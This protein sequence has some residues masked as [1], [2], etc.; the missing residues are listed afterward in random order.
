MSKFLKFI[1]DI[2]LYDTDFLRFV[3]DLIG[4]LYSKIYKDNNPYIMVDVGAN[5]GI[6][7][8]VMLKHTSNDGKVI[9]IDAHPNWKD[10]YL[11]NNHPT[12]VTYNIG[13]YSTK[14]EKIF[15]DTEKCSGM[16][17][18]GISPKFKEFMQQDKNLVKKDKIQCDTLDN[19]L[20]P[21]TVDDAKVSFIKIDAESADFEVILGAANTIK[22][23]RPIILFE[24][25]GQILERAHSHDR[26]DFFNFFK[27]N[28]YS[29]HSIIGGHSVKFIA[30]H[31]DTYTPEL[32]DILAIPTEFDHIVNLENINE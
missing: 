2:S 4:L 31:W 19:L 1:D 5:K 24:F 29:L 14:T 16:G 22:Q 25:S 17:F 9:A 3:D 7:S 23:N 6:V 11:F 13:C 27:L 18:I 32:H 15:I 12:I 21:H 28:N 30:N 8:D 26:D 10:I 20:K